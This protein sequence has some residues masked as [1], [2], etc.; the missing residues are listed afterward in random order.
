MHGKVLGSPDTK[1]MNLSEGICLHR[2]VGSSSTEPR[3]QAR[4]IV[5]T[6]NGVCRALCHCFFAKVGH[7]AGGLLQR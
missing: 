4:L 2:Y 6:C 3:L 5:S 1:V 7:R